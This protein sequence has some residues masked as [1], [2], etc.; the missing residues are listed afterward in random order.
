LRL[1]IKVNKIFIEKFKTYGDRNSIVRQDKVFTYKDKIESY[2]IPQEIIIFNDK[3]LFNQR[4][5]K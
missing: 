3:E 4:L 2:K 1:A 5:K